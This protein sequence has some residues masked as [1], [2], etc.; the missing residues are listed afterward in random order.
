[1]TEPA[2]QTPTPTLTK[3]EIQA[4]KA[5]RRQLCA[6]AIQ[7]ACDYYECDIVAVAYQNGGKIEARTELV[8]K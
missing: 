4:Q 1:M 6:A 3:A 8:L 7:A 2:Q 5:L